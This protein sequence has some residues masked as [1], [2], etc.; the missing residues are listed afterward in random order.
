MSINCLSSSESRTRERNRCP[1]DHQCF[2]ALQGGHRSVEFTYRRSDAGRGLRRRSRRVGAVRRVADV[3]VE[4]Y[5]SLAATGRGTARCLRC[6]S[7]S[8]GTG[9]KQSKPRRWN[10]GGTAAQSAAR[11]CSAASAYRPSED[12]IVLYTRSVLDYHPN[13]M[14]LTAYAADDITLH[15]QT[16]F[17]VGGRIRRHRGRGGHRSSHC[18]RRRLLRSPRPQNCSRSPRSREGRS[19]T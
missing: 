1:N 14:T 19:A 4:L 15:R 10:P 18:R 7:A 8:R 3:R 9:P 17:S 5:G 13:G 11:S 2:R 6:C 16:Y 12:D